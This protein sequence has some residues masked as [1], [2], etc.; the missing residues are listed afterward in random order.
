[1]RVICL[2]LARTGTT[3]LSAALEELGLKPCYRFDNLLKDR[4]H[5]ETFITAFDNKYGN[6]GQM[7]YRAN[8][9]EV[10]GR[11]GFDRLF[12][13]HMVGFTGTK[14]CILTSSRLWW[15]W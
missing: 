10:I 9:G 13:Q 3:S 8:A 14:R 12:G 7:D 6:C 5:T 11:D 4:G 15:A 1:M 2:G